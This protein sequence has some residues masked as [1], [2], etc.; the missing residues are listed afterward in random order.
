[1]V[2]WLKIGTPIRGMSPVMAALTLVLGTRNHKKKQELAQLLSP[3]G[4]GL[5]TL[6]DFPDALVVEETGATFA[7]NA[8]LK[9]VEQARH[10]RHWVLGEDSGLS[11]DA[12]DGAPGVYSSRF[13]GPQATDEQ[14]NDLLLARLAKVPSE[15]RTAHYTC[16]ATLADSLGRIR[17][18]AEATCRG[19]IRLARAGTGGFGYD[20]LFEIQEYHQTFGEMG[21]AVKG[22]LSHRARAIRLVIP[23]LL[24]LAQ[25]DLGNPVQSRQRAP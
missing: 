18:D 9:A 1:M 23:V 2:E 13:A 8:A 24:E 3:H 19:R 15:K 5:L 14:N 17:F 11:V 12:L 16:H 7:E 22:I 4:V 6:S 25:S 10:L 21:D 20:P